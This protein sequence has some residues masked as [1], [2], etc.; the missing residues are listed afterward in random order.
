M[1]AGRRP[2]GASVI[3]IGVSRD[4]GRTFT[5]RA[6]AA[7]PHQWAAEVY[8]P[9]ELGTGWPPCQCPQHREAA[10]LPHSR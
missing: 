4:S 5:D 3:R 9:F 10:G 1:S 6:T 8:G 2:E 7:I